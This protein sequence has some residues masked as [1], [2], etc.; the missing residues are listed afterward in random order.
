MDI[1]E[2]KEMNLFTITW[3]IF[4]EV[5]L[6]MLMGNVDTM[7]LSRVSDNSVAAVGV[8]NQ[9]ISIAIVLFDFVAAGSSIIIAQYL[10]AKKENEAFTVGSI[11]IGINILFGLSISIIMF[12]FSNFFLEM[13]NIPRNLQDIA[14]IYLMVV[15]G[16]LFIQ[17]AMMAAGTVL[18]SYKYTKDA[19]YI[20][21]GMNILNI[22]GNSIFIFG[23]FGAPKIGVT[24]VAISTVVSKCIGFVV[25]M[26]LLSKRLKYTYEL[27][28]FFHFKKE[29]VKKIL[30]IGVPSAGEHLAYNISQVMV[31]FFVTM[32]GTQALATKVYAQNLSVFIFLFAVSVGIGT[33]ILV[34]HLVGAGKNDDAY[35]QC[36]RSLKISLVVTLSLAG[37]FAI[38]GKTL[39]GLF[40]DNPDIIHLG[41]TLLLLNVLLEPGRTF[42]LVVISALKATGDVTFPVVMGIVSMWGISVS[43][44]YVLGITLGLGLVGVWIAYAVDE[45]LRG[46]IMIKRWRNRTWEKKIMVQASNLVE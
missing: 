46:Y 31:T 7:M 17:S 2:K 3:P 1:A 19:M 29:Y 34:A 4:I 36:I 44:S 37:T 23:L 26:I 20:T 16:F 33:Q 18:R 45:W 25:L 27:K 11:A 41:A 43:L 9:I 35:Y 38:L 24:G 39:M 6:Y 13:M 21:L 8:S 30:K 28:K 42:N 12:F 14:K 10:G 15:G 32:M 5:F 22:I 40:T